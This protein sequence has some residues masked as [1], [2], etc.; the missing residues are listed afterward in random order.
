VAQVQVA[1]AT[2]GEAAVVITNAPGTVVR[3][4]EVP[5]TRG[6]NTLTWDVQAARPNG[7]LQ[8]APAG[9]YTVQ[10]RVGGAQA[11]GTVRVLADPILRR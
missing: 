8:D 7:E 4:W 3:R 6:V 11:S 9:T 5:V 1:S 10:V 2:A